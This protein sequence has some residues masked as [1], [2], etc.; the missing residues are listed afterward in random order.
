MKKSTFKLILATLFVAI[1][2]TTMVFAAMAAE[3]TGYVVD[4]AGEETN[5]KWTITTEGSDVICTFE[6]DKSATDKIE[7][8]IIYGFDP[9]TRQPAS[10]G[11]PITNA[12]GKDAGLTKI[13]I[14]DGITEIG[15]GA[16]IWNP[17]KTME[18]PT[19][20][21][22]LG[23][24]SLQACVYLETVYVRG[25]TP[26]QYTF[27]FSNVTEIAEVGTFD[28]CGQLQRI[29]LNEN[30]IGGFGR[31]FFKNTELVEIEIPASVTTIQNQAFTRNQ[32][33]A[34][35]KVLGRNTSFESD[36]VFDAVSAYPVIIGYSGSKAESFAR[37]NDFTF[38]DIET[39]ETI[40]EGSRPVPAGPPDP[41]DPLQGTSIV[42]V[43]SYKPAGATAFGHITAKFNGNITANTFWAYY[44]DTKT[45]E[46]TAN[47]EGYCETG[48][49]N[50]C[51]DGVGWSAYKNEI[52]HVILNGFGGGKVAPGA[53]EG[54][55]A[56]IDVMI[57]GATTVPQW[58]IDAFKDCV[59]LTTIWV[60]GRG[61]TE[62]VAD[63]HEAVEVSDAF[64]NTKI[65]VLKLGG[66]I[67]KFSYIMPGNIR[68]LITN[69]VDALDAYCKENS[70]DLENLNDPSDVRKYYVEIPEGAFM[71]GPRAA[72]KFDEATGKLEIFGSGAISDIANYYGGG[73][74][75]Q[76]WFAFRDNVKSLVIGDGITTIG[77]Y[78]FCELDNLETVE[79]P[80]NDTLVILNA[81]F[82]KCS[83]IVSIYRRGDQPIQGTIDIRGISEIKAWTYAYH[84]LIAN[85][86]L[87]PEVTSISKSAFEEGVNIKNIYG[88]PGTYAE[89]Y[90]KEK[91]YTFYD[92]ATNTP[93]PIE[94]EAPEIT[95]PV[96]DDT[97]EPIAPDTTDTD[98]VDTGDTTDVDI[99]PTTGS[100]T[101]ET[102]TTGD[103]VD[104]KPTIG[105]DTNDV[106]S[107]EGGNLTT[108][109][110]I[111]AA[112]VVVAIVAVIVIIVSKKKKTSS[113]E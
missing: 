102:E 48:N 37:A 11:S 2:A 74:K 91:G 12:W 18:I 5:I 59:N 51:D 65:E 76:P 27:D 36:K 72:Y 90:A 62:G 14:G 24:F 96:E 98:V 29:K 53:F 87:S 81:A 101:P 105:I 47:K 110:I 35:V 83:K 39:N 60:E 71:C 85:V 8:T 21:K 97:T 6:I 79:I 108:I 44:K 10:Y 94:C 9:V 111:V 7:S 112:V 25:T 4:G 75:N 70:I 82:E 63:L 15:D 66:A 19:S 89:E 84:H 3:T 1:L 57:K 103:D 92:I 55:T 50:L 54:H 68:K 43:D 77:K 20:L 64:S 33:L 34:T 22:K 30:L 73:S 23:V 17:V 109:I 69:Q 45:L 80:A 100:A 99:T 52:E 49:L 13:I 61:R 31:E 38:I 56:L 16:F 32:K 113:A 104:T 95:T 86:V 67:D 58:T 78:A 46:L 88:T 93:Q 42:A 106:D 40:F 26:V 107:D 41:N 28:A